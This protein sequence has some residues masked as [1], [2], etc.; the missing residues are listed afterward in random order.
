MNKYKLMFLL[1]VAVWVVVIAC[2]M[3]T[4]AKTEDMPLPTEEGRLPGDETPAV[5]VLTYEDWF[6]MTANHVEDCTITHY[7][8]EQYTHICGTGGGITATGVPVTPYWTCAVDPNV[9]PFGA[10]VM[11]DYGDSVAFYK[12]QDCGGSIDG[13][14]IDLAVTAHEEALEEGVKTADVYWLFGEVS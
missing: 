6:R 11:V 8:A 9:I 7:C 12:A 5:E 2:T 10:E 4:P 14:H 13:N 1:A 3:T